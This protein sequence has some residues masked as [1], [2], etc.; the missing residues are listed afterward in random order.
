[1]FRRRPA[2]DLESVRPRCSCCGYDLRATVTAA[3]ATCSECGADLP[4]DR[5]RF[6]RRGGSTVKTS[7]VLGGLLATVML[8]VIAGGVAAFVYG[9]GVTRWG[10]AILGTLAAMLVVFR[11]AWP[12]AAPG[13]RGFA[14]VALTVITFVATPAEGAILAGAFVILIVTGVSLT[15]GDR[16][17]SALIGVVQ[18]PV[19]NLLATW[20]R[21]AKSARR[22]GSRAWSRLT[23]RV[24]A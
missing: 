7:V 1:V 22:C 21:I 24:G 11:L 23:R 15:H 6:P 4:F 3:G 12:H 20:R 9:G 2:Y 17:A 8:A 16:R 19:A 5:L 18:A 13:V 10:V 14:A